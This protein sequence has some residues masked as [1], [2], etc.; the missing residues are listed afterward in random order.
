M[1]DPVILPSGKTVDRGT[2]TRHVLTDPTDPF[3]RQKFSLD[4]LQPSTTA[5]NHSNII[6]TQN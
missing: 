2:I 5:D 1:E 4:M 3:N 6:Q